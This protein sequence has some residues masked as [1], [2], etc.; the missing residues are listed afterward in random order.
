MREVNEGRNIDIGLLWLDETLIKLS[1]VK[2][3]APKT[4]NASYLY[5]TFT[6]LQN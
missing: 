4:S 5:I 1:A 6:G 3:N 2:D